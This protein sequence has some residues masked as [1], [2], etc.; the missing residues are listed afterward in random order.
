MT[1]NQQ[2]GLTTSSLSLQV[3]IKDGGERRDVV[4]GVVRAQHN[5]HQSAGE[6]DDTIGYFARDGRIRNSSEKRLTGAT[7]IR[8]GEDK[9]KCKDFYHHRKTL[10]P[11]F[12]G[13]MKTGASF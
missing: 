2:S 3:L 1:D 7:E 11:V 6:V 5:L 12:E 13:Q 9:I 8:E 10:L 4:V